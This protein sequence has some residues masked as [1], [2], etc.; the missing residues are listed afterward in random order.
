[1]SEH[2]SLYKWPLSDAKRMGEGKWWQ[3]S[4]NENCL[5]ARAIESAISDN[6]ADNCLN[7]D[8]A[9]EIIETYGFDRVNYVLANTVQR[10]SLDG[11]FDA[12]NK[13]WADSFYIPNE[14]ARKNFTVK[15]HPGLT[16]L[17]I[18]RIRKEWDAIGLFNRSHCTENEY[19]EDKLLVMKPS[20]LKDQYKTPD[21]QLF[22]ATSGF[23][24]D[25]HKI[26]TQVT[27][28]FLKDGEL[29]HFRRD[30]FIG[31]IKLECIPEWAKAELKNY[32]E[33]EEDTGIK[34]EGV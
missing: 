18:N 16:N 22:F 5:C 6:Y 1:M 20:T 26:G 15:S 3:E 13:E 12:E 7:T 19:Y 24:C 4:Y 27:G 32:I 14:D 21:Y 29:V 10:S 30:D 31:E 33:P 8:V 17:F 23:G 9:K 28:Y 34:M 11:R 2:K 25:P